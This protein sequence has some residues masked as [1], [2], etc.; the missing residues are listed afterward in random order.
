M[1]SREVSPVKKAL[2]SKS[3]KKL[4]KG[5]GH[6]PKN[7]KNGNDNLQSKGTRRRWKLWWILYLS[8][9]HTKN[10]LIFLNVLNWS[11][12]KP[13]GCGNYWGRHIWEAY[14]CSCKN[15]VQ[16]LFFFPLSHASP[17]SHSKISMQVSTS[18]L[19]LVLSEKVQRSKVGILLVLKKPLVSS[20]LT[21]NII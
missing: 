1:H 8:K 15:Y 19:P 20:A 4:S 2:Q 17:N 13:W 11:H 16:Q 7:G 18:R 14:K 5:E 10:S 12:R 6:A 9:F 3:P 21:I